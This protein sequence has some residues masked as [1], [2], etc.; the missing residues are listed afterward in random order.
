MWCVVVCCRVLCWV[1][2]LFQ[3]TYA[4]VGAGLGG[5]IG[6]LLMERQGGQGLFFTAAAMVAAG[7]LAGAVVG[8]MP[9]LKFAHSGLKH[10]EL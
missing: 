1:Q 4:G 9:A 3:S 10:K 7:G 8:R 2:G 5:L 6:G